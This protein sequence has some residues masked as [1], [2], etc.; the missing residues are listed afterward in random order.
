MIFPSNIHEGRRK[1]IERLFGVLQS[2]FEILRREVR[3]WDLIYILAYSN[4]CI[5]LHNMIVRILQ[6]GAFSEEVGDVDVVS[7]LFL[8]Q[9]TF[10]VENRRK[11]RQNVIVANSLTAS[12]AQGRLDDL[13]LRELELTYTH[14]HDKLM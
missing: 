7:E 2:R 6:E 14:S 10:T 12:D 8:Q 11:Y 9:L 1:D 3:V 13:L 4:T 5:I